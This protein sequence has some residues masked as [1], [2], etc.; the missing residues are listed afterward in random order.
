VWVEI[1]KAHNRSDLVAVGGALMQEAP[2]M[3][4]DVQVS[5]ARSTIQ[6]PPLPIVNSGG[7]TGGDSGGDDNNS[8][9]GAVADVGA[10]SAI[11]HTKLLFT[12]GGT[13][14]HTVLSAR[15]A[16]APCHPY[17]AGEQTCGNMDAA[18][19]HVSGTTAPYNSR[20]SEPWR[21]YSEMFWSG[22]LTSK[23]ASEIVNF[24][25]N[26]TKLSRMGVWSGGGGFD[27]TLVA[28][29]EQGTVLSLW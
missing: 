12:P 1:G 25:Q 9:V 27:N 2:I 20:A 15:E 17:V 4:A 7:G 18:G 21:T 8:Y 11:V 19:A 28:F 16:A 6:T 10:G 29:T 3:L 13:S 23:D 22:G 5:M 26:S 24:N 14:S